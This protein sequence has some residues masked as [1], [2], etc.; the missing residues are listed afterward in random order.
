MCTECDTSRQTVKDLE[1]MLTSREAA[2]QTEKFCGAGEEEIVSQEQRS[3]GGSRWRDT[4]VAG[5]RRVA[6][7]DGTIA[8]V[9]DR[10]IFIIQKPFIFH[11]RLRN[12]SFQRSKFLYY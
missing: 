6:D 8:K 1:K 7:I 12:P 5:R 10:I 11:Y 2:K 4:S 9:Y 3:G